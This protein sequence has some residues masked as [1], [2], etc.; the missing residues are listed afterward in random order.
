MNKDQGLTG[1][2]TIPRI[3][4]AGGMAGS[5][6]QWGVTQ[7]EINRRTH[8]NLQLQQITQSVAQS[9][10]RSAQQ[11]AT[12]RQ[13]LSPHSSITNPSSKESEIKDK[14]K[15]VVK[16]S[17]KSYDKRNLDKNVAELIRKE[18]KE[19]L[20]Y[21]MKF[22]VDGMIDNFNTLE[23]NNSVLVTIIL[24]NTD[25]MKVAK[26]SGKDLEFGKKYELFS[27][28][29]FLIPRTLNDLRTAKTKDIRV[30]M[31]AGIVGYLLFVNVMLN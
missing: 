4:G 23:E 27:L 3:S 6:D 8:H 12:T 7:E 1:D 25:E 26:E 18:I 13:E 14:Q 19:K 2:I 21:N 15:Q 9:L 16:A 17:T 28:Y 11:N 31:I 29:N 10:Q 5:I 20:W 24:N 22:C 30:K